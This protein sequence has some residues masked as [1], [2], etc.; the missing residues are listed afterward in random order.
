MTNKQ[1]ERLIDMAEATLEQRSRTFTAIRT[2][3]LLGVISGLA[4]GELTIGIGT[5]LVVGLGDYFLRPIFV[6]M[7]TNQLRGK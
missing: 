6:K 5:G 7:R 2:A 1:N 3:A 4:S